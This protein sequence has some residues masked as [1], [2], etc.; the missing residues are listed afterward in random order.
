MPIFQKS[1]VDKY[2][3]TLDAGVLDKAYDSYKEV[4][5]AQKIQRIKKLCITS[6]GIQGHIKWLVSQP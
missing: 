5:T 3:E 2:L 4:Y 1:I 6:L